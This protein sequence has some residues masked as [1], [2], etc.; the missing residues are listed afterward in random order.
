MPL[1]PSE[2]I[3]RFLSEQT[4]KQQPVLQ[5]DPSGFQYVGRKRS[6]KLR[7]ANGV[8][9]GGVLTTEEWVFA[10]REAEP[11]LRGTVKGTSF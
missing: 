8:G 4:H 6:E 5:E 11:Q 1:W 10:T 9:V 7:L 3:D 2:T